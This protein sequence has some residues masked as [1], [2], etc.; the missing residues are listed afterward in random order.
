M[1]LVTGKPYPQGWSVPVRGCDMFVGIYGEARTR[2][3]PFR[4]LM[5][6]AG[7]SNVTDHLDMRPNQL[8]DDICGGRL[9]SNRVS[10][11]HATSAATKTRRS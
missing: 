6:P 10:A 9:C 2:P 7:P 8:P 11:W 5:L 3:V 4:P 1:T